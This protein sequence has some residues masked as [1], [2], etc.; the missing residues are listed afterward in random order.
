M[1][2]PYLKKLA[3]ELGKSEKELEK[4]WSKA[5]TLAAETFGV[6]EGDF[7]SREYKYSVG[8]VK[9]MLGMNES[10]NAS[11]FI[12]SGKNAKDFVEDAV[13]TSGDFSI[14]N[15]YKK[16]KKK[17][18]DDED[19]DV[20]Q[21]IKS[22]ETKNDEAISD[23]INNLPEKIIDFDDKNS[24]LLVVQDRLDKEEDKKE[25]EA[26]RKKAKADKRNIV[27]KVADAADGT[28]KRTGE[29]KEIVSAVVTAA[30]K[31][32]DRRDDI[33]MEKAKV[34][35]REIADRERDKADKDKDKEKEKADKERDKTVK[36]KDKEK[37]QKD[38]DRDRD[39]KRKD[40]ITQQKKKDSDVVYKKKKSKDITAEAI[41]DLE[42]K[43][44]DK[45]IE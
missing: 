8:I 6:T 23:A 17:K 14:G 45:S 1:P 28:V 20:K 30:A 18:K 25:K 21:I 19:L 39:Q 33:E 5:K 26:E 16:K 34:K 38:R 3:Q 31:A 24:N 36:D 9:Q 22:P 44:G 42:N 41:E 27:Q 40:D 29:K 37:A 13:V 11:S 35:D 43:Y 7:K 2:S 12:Q 4:Y 32:N 10:I 15:V